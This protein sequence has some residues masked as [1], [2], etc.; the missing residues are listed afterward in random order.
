MKIAITEVGLRDGLQNEAA[1]LPT[2]T[3]LDLIGKL[4]ACG[5]RSIDAAA[6]VSPRAVPQMADA[7]DVIR[8]IQ[9][10]PGARVLALTPNIKGVLAAA[11]AGA[12]EAALFLSASESHNA[13]NL[14]RSI[15]GSLEGLANIA[16]AAASAGI[17]LKGS[18]AVAFGCPFEGDVAVNRVVEIA[19]AYAGAGIHRLM[20]GDTTGMATPAIV[21]Q[22]CGAIL[23]ALP[24]TEITLHFH[25]SRGLALVNVAAALDMGI[26]RYESALGGTGGC[27]FAPG[28]TGNV[29]T[30]D[31]VHFLHE[32]GHETGIDLDAL[33]EVARTFEVLL[34]HPL[35]GQVM[36]TGPRLRLH[37]LDSVRTATAR[38]CV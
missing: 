14:N 3:K 23:E 35:P 37:P 31:L 29:C 8:G 26:T 38:E 12:D 34:G 32:S 13:K 28:A 20:L 16:E 10:P 2:A 22:V 11:E 25:N 7:A 33:I 36:R 15:A 4:F 1:I 5:I 24:D 19:R 30:E 27:P 18:I 6:F 21:R 9:A 17:A